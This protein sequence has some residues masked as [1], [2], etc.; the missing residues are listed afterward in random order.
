MKSAN[1]QEIQIVVKKL[2]LN[3]SFFDW[4]QCDTA[5][6]RGYYTT[7]HS[8]NGK[9]PTYTIENEYCTRCGLHS[10]RCIYYTIILYENPDLLSNTKQ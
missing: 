10:L 6:P 7:V 1:H 5:K 2:D 8:I 3:K 9:D 4:H